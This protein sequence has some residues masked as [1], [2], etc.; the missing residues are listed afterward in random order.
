MLTSPREYQQV[1]LE[2]LPP[3]GSLSEEDYLW[4]TDHSARLI[5]FTDGYAEVLPMPTDDHQRILKLLLWAFDRV[6]E[7][8]G[9]IV[10][11]APLRLRLREGKMREPDLMLLRDASDPRRQQR[12][13]TGADLVLEVVNT[14]QPARDLVTKRQEYEEAGIPEY[15][16]VNPLNR[17]IVV[18][19]LLEGRYVEHGIFTSGMQATSVLLSGF[20]V[21]IDAILGVA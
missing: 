2:L 15:W 8:L 14:D 1:I 5:E 6:V 11:F 16:I 12:Y 7:P 21:E 18:L 20:A 10:L 19:A 13:W 9:G 17:T 4:L 3:Q